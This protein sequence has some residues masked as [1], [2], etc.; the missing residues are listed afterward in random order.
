MA[1][2]GSGVYAPPAA[3]YPAVA[4]T[5]IEST[6]FNNVI[7]DI[8]TA[9]SGS[10]AANG[11][12]TVTQNLPMNSKKFTGL[13]NG[14]ARTDSVAL[15]QVQDG[16]LNWVDGGGTV[17]AITAT[18]SPVITALVDGQICCVRAT[19]ANTITN[20]T[21]SPNGLTARII[22]KFGGQALEVGSIRSDQH[23]L[24]LR[25]DLANTRWELLNPASAALAGSASQAFSVASLDI[26]DAD[27]T[28][29][30]VSA[31]VVAVEGVNLVKQDQTALSC[32]FLAYKS[33]STADQTGDGTA[34][35][36]IFDTE[37]SDIGANYN[38]A[39]G[40]FTAPATGLYRLSAK[41]LIFQLA[42][43]HT[44]HELSLITSNRSYIGY[45]I[46]T[47]NPLTDSTLQLD[48][49]VDMDAGDTAYISVKVAGATKVVDVYGSAIQFT[50]FSGERVA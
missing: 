37:I 28:L 30:R 7:D 8:S 41:V 19:G 13:A 34:Y 21:F 11:E 50:N 32:A 35:T 31:G 5:L 48:E 25:Y 16:T 39:T 20:P 10:I 38:N 9:L 29:T 27:T 2:N 6:K 43:G 3:D 17:D 15:G 47:S 1:R 18:Y 26:G 24:I 49:L 12:T 44:T 42:A 46:Y 36:V 4:S 40:I 22:Y 23:E 45:E 14:S 33:S